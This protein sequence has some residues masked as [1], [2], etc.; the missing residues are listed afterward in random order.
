M[1]GGD[2]AE[3]QMGMSDYDKETIC[4]EVTVILRG[5]ATTKFTEHIQTALR[6]NV[7]GVQNILQLAKKCLVLRSF[8]H[9]ST[10]YV[11]FPQKNAGIVQE[12]VYNRT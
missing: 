9:I 4:R 3:P 8:V 2:V 6:V 5:A 12:A 1:V 11:N 10:A 7:L